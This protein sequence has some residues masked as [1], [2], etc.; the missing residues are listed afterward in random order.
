MP[1]TSTTSITARCGKKTSA[2]SSR[3]TRSS[4]RFGAIGSAGRCGWRRQAM[5]LSFAHGLPSSWRAA[6][7]DRHRGKVDN[8]FTVARRAD[9]SWEIIGH[10]EERVRQTASRRRSSRRRQPA[11]SPVERTLR[12]FFGAPTAGGTADQGGLI[13]AHRIRD[14]DY[15]WF[16]VSGGRL[17]AEGL[18]RSRDPFFFHAIALRDGALLELCVVRTLQLRRCL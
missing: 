11:L 18:A 17:F 15:E 1:I 16:G 3:A 6:A 14:L 2:V 13:E 4:G 9:M 10:A 7:H 5:I 12:K 8:T